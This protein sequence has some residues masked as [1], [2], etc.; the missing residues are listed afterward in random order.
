MNPPDESLL[1]T[2]QLTWSGVVANC[3]MN[4][5]RELSR[6]NSYEADLRFDIRAFLHERLQAGNVVRW[7]DLCCGRG[8]ALLQAANE[9]PDHVVSGRLELIGVDLVDDFEATNQTVPR[10]ITANI[11][12][13]SPAGKFDLITC[14]HGLHYVGDKLGM[15]ERA[16][17]WLQPAGEFLAHLDLGNLRTGDNRDLARTVRRWFREVG[18]EFH[19]RFRL[20][21]CTG[22]KAISWKYRYLGADDRAGPNFTG[23]PAVNSLYEVTT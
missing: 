2:D 18:L 12:T 9:F 19:P 4:R 21:H 13:W 17:R 15:I 10:L 11:Q 7:L 8:I 23:Q 16:C 20:L 5:E 6:R 22:A 1:S 3:R 14:V